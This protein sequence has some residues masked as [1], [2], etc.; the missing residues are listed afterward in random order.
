MQASRG[1]ANVMVKKSPFLVDFNLVTFYVNQ[2]Y[3]FKFANKRPI[4]K[5]TKCSQDHNIGPCPSKPLF[6]SIN[7]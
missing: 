1:G 3:D 6:S 7:V 4:S 2:F 5:L